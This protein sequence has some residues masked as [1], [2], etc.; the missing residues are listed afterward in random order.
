FLDN[1]VYPIRKNVNE[2]L[3]ITQEH[4][5]KTFGS[6]RTKVENQ[7][8]EIGNKFYCFNNN[9]SIVKIDNVKFYNLQFRVACLL[10]NI[11][12]FVELFNIPILPHHKLWHSSNFEFPTEKKIIDI[13]ISNNKQNKDKFDRMMQLQNNLLSLTISDNSMAIDEA[14]SNH[15]ENSESDNDVPNFNERTRK[16]RRNIKGNN[17]QLHH[18]K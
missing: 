12:K 8:S 3:T 4:F 6:F 18:M 7:F 17:V 2:N 1:F 13:V 10:K 16:R 9:K 14:E 15:S 5:N 11:T